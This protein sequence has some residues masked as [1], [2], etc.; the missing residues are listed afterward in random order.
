MDGIALRRAEAGDAEA[1]AAL[2]L[3]TFRETFLDG[4]AIPYPPDDLAAFL[5]AN[6]TPAA[7]VRKL[8]APG[9][10]MWIAE[11]SGEPLAYAAVGRCALP[12]P[13]ARA[14]DGELHRL[15]VL[16]TAQRLGVGRILLETAL[17]WLEAHTHGPL[18]LGVWSGNLKAQRLYAAYGF[19]KA[20]EYRFPVGGWL[21][22][23]FIMRRERRH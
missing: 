3:A 22:E 10:A 9:S 12:H 23:E 18:W 20:G 21:D 2:G 4:F 7:F 17:A 11:R 1:L 6:Y 19:E 5:E 14:E 13:G 15:Y 8:A 16:R